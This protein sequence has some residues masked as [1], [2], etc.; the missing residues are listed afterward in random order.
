MGD[1][2]LGPNIVL[3]VRAFVFLIAFLERNSLD[4]FIGNIPTIAGVG[5][6]VSIVP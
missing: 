5:G 2:V 3:A 4:F 6:K 1:D